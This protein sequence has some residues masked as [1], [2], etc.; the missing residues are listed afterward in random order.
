MTLPYLYKIQS[1]SL[2]NLGITMFKDILQVLPLK[3]PF[4]I[5]QK[6]EMYS[7]KYP[8]TQ[9]AHQTIFYLNPVLNMDLL[10]SA[11]ATHFKDIKDSRLKI[12]NMMRR[13]IIGFISKI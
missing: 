10:L 13:K 8:D 2:K 12:I 9:T 3:D 1:T 5:V 11:R 7:W 6:T 4:H